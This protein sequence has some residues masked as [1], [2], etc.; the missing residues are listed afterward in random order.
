MSFICGLK[1]ALTVGGVMPHSSRATGL[2]SLFRSVFFGV[3]KGRL[4]NAGGEVDVVH[5]RT[6]IRVDGGRSHAPLVAV[7]GLAELVPAARIFKSIGAL[8]V[9]EVIVRFDFERGVVAPFFRV[10]DL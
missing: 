7:D 9:A 4:Q 1:Y 8:N 6:E 2:P 3:I 5:L 10:A